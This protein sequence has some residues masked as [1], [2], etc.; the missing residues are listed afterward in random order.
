LVKKDDGE[1]NVPEMAAREMVVTPA[2][3]PKATAEN[4]AGW[5][6]SPMILV[7]CTPKV[8]TPP[9]TTSTVL[10]RSPGTSELPLPRSTSQAG[11]P[12]VPEF[13]T[14]WLKPEAK[15]QEE[16]IESV[17][18]NSATDR[19][20]TEDSVRFAVSSDEYLKHF[21]D[22][23]PPKIKQYDQLL[24]TPPPP[25]ITRIPDDVLQIL[26]KYNHKADP[27]KAKEM[28]TKAGAPTRYESDF[29]DYSNKENRGYPGLFKPNV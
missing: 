3:K 27:S 18:K 23:S 17:T 5:M 6:A 12:Q 2:P 20:Y 1:V 28:E 15:V 10:P 21:G 4:A 19:Q 24:S 29:T 13:Q 16:K 25:E 14:R 11:T 8:K 9:T 26:S 7:F 22:P